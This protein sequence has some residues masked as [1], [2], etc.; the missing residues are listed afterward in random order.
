MNATQA[1]LYTEETDFH[2]VQLANTETVLSNSTKIFNFVSAF[3]LN[4]IPTLSSFDFN[5]L[6]PQYDDAN[7]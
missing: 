7:P 2:P 6:N 4:H 3:L 5:H 1:V